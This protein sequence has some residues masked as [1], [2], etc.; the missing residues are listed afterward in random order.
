MNELFWFP[1]VGLLALYA[2]D[3]L[4]ALICAEADRQHYGGRLSYWWKFYMF[5]ENGR[6]IRRGY[7]K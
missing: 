2:L 3:A 5:S 6:K 1:T 7:W 4:D